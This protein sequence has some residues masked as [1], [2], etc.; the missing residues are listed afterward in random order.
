MHVFPHSRSGNSQSTSKRTDGLPFQSTPSIEGYI[1][2]LGSNG[3]NAAAAFRENLSSLKVCELLPKQG[4]PRLRDVICGKKILRFGYDDAWFD[5]F[6]RSQSFLLVSLAMDYDSFTSESHAIFPEW[7]LFVFRADHRYCEKK[8]GAVFFVVVGFVY[9]IWWEKYQPVAEY[10]Q[11]VIDMNVCLHEF[12][13]NSMN[14]DSLNWFA[15][16]HKNVSPD[17]RG[18]R[19]VGGIQGIGTPNLPI[20]GF[21]FWGRIYCRKFHACLKTYVT[22]DD[23][24]G[25]VVN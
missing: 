1:G 14:R 23:S 17:R 21:R 7:R 8:K 24:R 6:A 3:L 11:L 9:S 22:G 25:E 20:E 15:I 5:G 10:G 12:S 4:P 13:R 18:R 2:R 16:F 19:K